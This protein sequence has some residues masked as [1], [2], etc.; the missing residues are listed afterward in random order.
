L[1]VPLPIAHRFRHIVCT[2]LEVNGRG[3]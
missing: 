2:L 1:A 3:P